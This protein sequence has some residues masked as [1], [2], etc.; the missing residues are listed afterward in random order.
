MKTQVLVIALVLFVGL[1]SFKSDKK[2]SEAATTESSMLN[3][4]ITGLVIDNSTG[5]ALAGVE[6]SIEGTQLKTYTDFDGKF[7][8]ESIQ[9]GDYK[10]CTKYISYEM[11]ESQPIKVNRNEM[12]TLNLE[13]KTANE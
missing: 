3:N 13:L 1:N 12:H 9:P 2:A 4:S 10:V 8:F 6:I 11:K 7:A 5:E